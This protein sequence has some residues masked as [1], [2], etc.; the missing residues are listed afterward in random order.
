MI[1]KVTEYIRD[2]QKLNT[3][4]LHATRLHS[5]HSLQQELIGYLDSVMHTWSDLVNFMV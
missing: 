4:R 5:T 1:I 3:K 2:G